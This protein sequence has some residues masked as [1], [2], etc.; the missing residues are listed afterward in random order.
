MSVASKYGVA[1]DN[2]Q[3][4]QLV[5]INALFKCAR[6][7]SEV[8][9]KNSFT[10]SQAHGGQLNDSSVN[11]DKTPGLCVFHLFQ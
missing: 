7:H 2:L 11:G 8:R 1:L 9:S 4:L 6:S 3:L 10:S 5:D